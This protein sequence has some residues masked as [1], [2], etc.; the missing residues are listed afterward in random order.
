MTIRL[1]IYTL[2]SVFPVM[3]DCQ[4]SIPDTLLAVHT[5]EDTAVGNNDTLTVSGRDRSLPEFTVYGISKA[6]RPSCKQSKT[7]MQLRGI[8]SS[9]MSFKPLGLINKIIR[10][11]F[12]KRHK[13]TRIERTRR[14][15]HEYD[16]A[17]PVKE[18]PGKH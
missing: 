8:Q 9:D 12:K 3:A 1:I 14:I 15:L 11:L 2:L 10:L 7:D 17:L 4:A 5:S 13:E 16:T 6:K 18:I